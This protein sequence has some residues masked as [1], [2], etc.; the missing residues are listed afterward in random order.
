MFKPIV[1]LLIEF[2]VIVQV[3]EQLSRD[4]MESWQYLVTFERATASRSTHLHIIIT[5][6]LLCVF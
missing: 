3:K 5:Y 2:Y 6:S 1:S 4:S